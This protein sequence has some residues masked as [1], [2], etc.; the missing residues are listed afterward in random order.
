MK[1]A[2]VQVSSIL[3]VGFIA[4]WLSRSWGGL[5]GISTLAVTCIAAGLVVIG[6]A[7]H[8]RISLG[9]AAFICALGTGLVLLAALGVR[10]FL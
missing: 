3:V 5:W 1:G 6:S 8:Q 4:F 9:S 10:L 2:L 7:H